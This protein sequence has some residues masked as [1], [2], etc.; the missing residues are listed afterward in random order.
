VP[1]PDPSAGTV[2]AV[3]GALVAVEDAVF[4][5]VDVVADVTA[6]FG[7]GAADRAAAGLAAAG[8][9]A[10][11]FAAAG[12]ARALGRAGDA[13]RDEALATDRARVGA[14]RSSLI[15]AV[16]W[17]TSARASD[18]CFLRFASTSRAFWRRF[19]SLPNSFAVSFAALLA[20]A[21]P[22]G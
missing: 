1:S 13:A 22:A 18:A 15:R 14:G 20:P 7:F 5:R 17:A 16:S 12:F 21:A 2:F 4:R 8:F 6:T 11:G 10:A 3:R 19:S 9:A